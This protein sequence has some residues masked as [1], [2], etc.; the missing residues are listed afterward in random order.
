MSRSWLNKV[1]P[2]LLLGLLVAVG[3]R[4]W[5]DVG[6]SATVTVPVAWS[7]Q[8]FLA[9]TSISAVASASSTATT[10]P[11][12]FIVSPGRFGPPSLIATLRIFASG[13]AQSVTNRP[14]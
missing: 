3:L 1:A 7:P 13:P 14:T 11:R 4:L 12:I 2:V 9:A 8:E 10:R 5:S 6:G